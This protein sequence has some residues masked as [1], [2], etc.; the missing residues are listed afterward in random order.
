MALRFVRRP[1]WKYTIRIFNEDYVGVTVERPNKYPHRSTM[2]NKD[3]IPK[4][5]WEATAMLDVARD[6]RGF[7]QVDGFGSVADITYVLY[8]LER[9]GE[10]NEVKT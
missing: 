3:N 6:S 8:P 10:A 7:A 9:E 2:Y 1:T 5:V 4:W